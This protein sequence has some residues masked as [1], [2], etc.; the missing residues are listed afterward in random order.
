MKEISLLFVCLFWGVLPTL[1]SQNT[2][3][4]IITNGR[5]VDG[6]GNQW[7]KADLGIKNGKIAAIGILKGQTANQIIDAEDRVVTPGFIDVH[8]HIEGSIL[9]RPEAKN[10]LHDGVTSMIT[11]N[12]GGSRTDLDQFFQE[13]EEAGTGINVAS[14]IGHNSVRRQVMGEDN[15]APSQEELQQMKDLVSKA[16]KD[17]AVGLSTGLLYVPGTFAKTDEIVELAKVIAPYSAV[18]T[19][20]IRFQ[21]GRVYESIAEAVEIGRQAK[22]PVEISHIKIKGKNSWGGSPKIIQQLEQYRKDGID[23]TV[24]QYPYTAAS[25]GLSVT[26]P[27][28]AQAGGR[29]SLKVR[30]NDP[31]MRKRIIDGMEELQNK[32]GFEDY[33][34]AYVANCPWNADY[35]GK[36]IPEINKMKGRPTGEEHERETILEMMEKGKRV[37][38]IYHYM[39]EEDVQNLMKY[40]GTMIA[41]DGGIPAFGQGNPHPRSYGTNV[42]VLAVYVRNKK[43]FSLEEA[44]RKMTA[45][46][47]RR[48]QLNDRGLLLPG[49]AADILIFDPEKVQD[50]AEYSAPHAY[51]EGMKYVIVN[52]EMVIEKGNYTEQKPGQILKGSANTPITK[53]PNN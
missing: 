19:S 18:Y 14:L 26:V 12:C 20:H 36:S 51:S 50:K 29:D 30:L 11:G 9:K 48:F 25:T 38:M 49:Y 3:D 16:L 31:S 42:R 32:L 33:S 23:V 8:G 52:G 24:D 21:D 37:Q 47:A 43:L 53:Y 44:I 6:T 13:L 1:F 28:W 10:L 22:V 4:L 46:P 27:T 2:Y 5:I 34:Y 15:R 40:E 41:S 39:G 7:F 45:L 35:N 17:G